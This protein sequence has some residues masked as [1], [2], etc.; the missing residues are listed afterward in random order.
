MS[1]SSPIQ[2]CAEESLP[3]REDRK[4]EEKSIS[5]VKTGK[6]EAYCHYFQIR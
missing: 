2:Y 3:V 1:G 6:E 5:N 4:N